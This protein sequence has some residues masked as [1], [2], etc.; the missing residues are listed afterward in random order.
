MESKQYF[1]TFQPEQKKRHLSSQQYTEFAY[2]ANIQ[3]ENGPFCR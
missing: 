2:R 1:S 3:Y